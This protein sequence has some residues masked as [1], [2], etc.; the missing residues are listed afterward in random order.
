MFL[1]PRLC[2]KMSDDCE[3]RKYERH[4]IDNSDR[5]IEK[6]KKQARRYRV[7]ESRYNPRE[8]R[9]TR[10]TNLANI[11]NSQEC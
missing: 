9:D 11:Y 6:L 2:I 3:D 8:V 4:F 5:V 1:G 7:V 10:K